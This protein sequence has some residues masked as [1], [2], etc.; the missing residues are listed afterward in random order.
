MVKWLN[1][2]KISGRIWRSQEWDKNAK[3]L[4]ILHHNLY[5]YFLVGRS[6]Y[7][8]TLVFRIKAQSRAMGNTADT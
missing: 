2:L 3:K 4:V 5:L 7:K 1:G 8:F 6:D